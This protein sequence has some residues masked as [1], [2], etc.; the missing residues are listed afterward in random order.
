[1]TDPFGSVDTL[2]YD[3]N[4]F[5]AQNFPDTTSF[6]A[7][8]DAEGRFAGMYREVN[9]IEVP[10]EA[11]QLYQFDIDVEGDKSQYQFTALELPEDATAT[12]GLINWYPTLTDTGR[13]HISVKIVDPSGNT[14]TLKHDIYVFLP[15]TLPDTTSAA[16]L[17]TTTL[18]PDTTGALSR[19]NALVPSFS[20]AASAVGNIYADP[21]FLD[22]TV[23]RFELLSGVSPGIDAGTPVSALNDQFRNNA[24]PAVPNENRNDMGY[25]G[26]PFNSGPP[27][28]KHRMAPLSI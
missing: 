19:L 10:H 15:G 11:N 24:N 6:R 13:S 23:N 17:I 1:M 3:L 18:T 7:L 16:R 26:G 28:R 14:D 27:H 4:V 8:S 21:V 9:T 2:S 5:T 12:D 20:S 25:L 22:T